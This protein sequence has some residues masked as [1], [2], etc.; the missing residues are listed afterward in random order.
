MA[1][2]RQ[3]KRSL[4]GLLGTIAVFQQG[5]HLPSGMIRI[6][7]AC[8]SSVTAGQYPRR[9]RIAA[10]VPSSLRLQDHPQTAGSL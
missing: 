10:F 8:Y 5:R 6:Q 3:K 1:L 7:T 4:G 2:Y 9:W